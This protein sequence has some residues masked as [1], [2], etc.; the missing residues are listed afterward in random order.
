MGGFFYKWRRPLITILAVMVL[1]VSLSYTAHVRGRVVEL[2]NLVGTIVSPASSSLAFIGHQAGVGVSTVGQLF[3]LQAQNREL[4]QKLLLYNS[5]KL[6]LSEVLAANSRLRGLLGLQQTL[7]SW[8]LLP[9]SIIARNPD[10]W[11]STLVID[12]GSSSGV[13]TGMSV[14]VPQGVVGRIVAVS[15]TSSTVM[16]ILDPNS[17]VGAMDTR[18]QAAGV[19]LGQDPITGLLKFQLFSHR[20]DILPGDAVVTSG[21]SQYYPK[22]LLLGQ[23]TSVSRVQFGLTEVAT[24]E[25]SVDFNRLQSV[26]VVLSH[27]TGTSAPPI[28][29]G[30][31]S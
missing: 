25:P 23:V 17:G 7:S 1:A 3:T 24:V 14:I 18:S 2:S 21:F 11:F 27:P 19:L 6:E 31:N 20:P 12:R 29:G 26:M 8:K 30:G 22:G 13:K 5:M 28:Y 10:N 16:L 15:S 4:K 9:A